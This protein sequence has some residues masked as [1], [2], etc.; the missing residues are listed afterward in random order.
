MKRKIGLSVL[1]F[2]MFSLVLSL[3]QCTK[4]NNLISRQVLFGNPDKASLE[5]SAN[6][7]MISY[8]APLDDVLNVWIAPAD[9]PSAAVA[10]TKDTLRGIRVYFWAYN[11][12]Q[13]VYL[14]DL[15]G[16]ENWQVH[17]V[18]VKTKEDKNLTPFEEIIGPD[19]EPITLPNGKKMRPRAEI[20]EVSY[21]FP[22]EIL[23]GL[24]NRNPQFHDIYQLN[25]LTGKMELVQQND[26]FLGFQ[27][28][29][30]YNIRYALQMTPD[31]GN[32]IF[33]P[34][35]KGGW[36]SFDKIPMEDML[37]T[38]PITFDKTGNILY[39]IDSRGRNTAALLSINL[40]TGDKEVIFE[41]PRADLSDIMIHPT[42]KT[43]E[44]AASN[45][46]RTEWKILDKSIQE[47]I[48]YLQKVADGDFNVTS[49]SLDDAKI[50]SR[51]PSFQING[52]E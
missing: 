38:G 35:G 48:D 11:N 5:I 30:D 46:T 45:Y 52:A 40:K 28:D 3:T 20:Q 4:E 42:E 41:D 24:N 27:T 16:N 32:E 49:R 22:N 15:G 51:S 44:A 21:K 47:D 39:M 29:D 17:A 31:G 18:N 26:R 7:Q 9:D 14:Q 8:L 43:I 2:I 23:I 36:T 6:H 37:S 34:N 12:E 25:L 13:I 10:V 19:N 33:V 1:I 50:H